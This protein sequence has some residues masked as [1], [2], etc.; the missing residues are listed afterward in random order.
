VILA[1]GFISIDRH[2]NG[3]TYMHQPKIIARCLELLGL[4][5]TSKRHDIPDDAN[6]IL[7]RN[8]N[9]PK[10]TQDWNY[11]SVIGVLN[12][13]Q[14][15]TRPD[16]SYAV[17][18]CARFCQAPKASHEL[19]VKRI[20]RYLASTKDKGIILTPN[21][22]KGFECYVDADWA[23]N[24]HDDYA[25]DDASVLSRTGYII[26]Y[27]GCPIIWSS[28]MQT[29]IA[30][31]TTE[32][33]YIALSSALRKVITLMNILSELRDFNIPIPTSTPIIRCR[34]FED[35]M[36]A[37]ELAREPK[38]CPHTKLLAVRLHHFRDH[39][40]RKLITIKHVSTKEQV[41]DIITKP[42]ARDQ[43]CNL[44]ALLM[45]W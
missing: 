7:Q 19:A 12:Y 26:T 38:F 5:N 28:K 37:L 10:R 15:M 35:N 43:F 16:I 34:V 6:I 41:A 44:R 30:L 17:H 14:A 1:Q 18:K 36:A 2:A 8:T 40:R 22:S 25:N 39:I 9:G 23:G 32:A 3:T 27:A 33:E 4:N 24:W 45:G 42:L 31:S 13:V 21:P 29:L 11:R 20:G